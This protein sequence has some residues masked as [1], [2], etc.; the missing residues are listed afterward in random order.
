ALADEVAK[1]FNPFLQ[2]RAVD[3]QLA[4]QVDEVIELAQLEAHAQIARC[5]TRGLV[6]RWSGVITGL[7]LTRQPR[8]ADILGGLAGKARVALR[9]RTH[10]PL[11]LRRVGNLPRDQ[12]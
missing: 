10:T 6:C 11:L 1:P 12:L 8:C 3:Q 5:A 9:E 2:D 4:E 7:G